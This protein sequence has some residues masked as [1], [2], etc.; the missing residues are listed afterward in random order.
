MF[1]ANRICPH[2]GEDA[3]HRG[4]AIAKQRQVN[5]SPRRPGHIGLR[6]E[7]IPALASA[8]TSVTILGI[9]LSLSMSCSRCALPG[10]GLARMRSV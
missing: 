2:C 5:A 8:I 7:V 3:H 9:N 10:K 1:R 4:A 6:R